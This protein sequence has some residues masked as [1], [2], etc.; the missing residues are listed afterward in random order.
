MN[1]SRKTKLYVFLVKTPDWSDYSVEIR[2]TPGGAGNHLYDLFGYMGRGTEICIATISGSE[3]IDRAVRVSK[4]GQEKRRDPEMF[5]HI[6]RL[7]AK[8]EPLVL[9]KGRR[10]KDGD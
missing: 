2:S 7:L 6:D 8:A 1:L 10:R 3:I 9:S 5:I 4:S